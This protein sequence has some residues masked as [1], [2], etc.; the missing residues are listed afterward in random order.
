MLELED[1]II[2]P[3]FTNHRHFGL[4]SNTQLTVA[5]I[6]K[7]DDEMVAPTPG[8]WIRTSDFLLPKE[9]L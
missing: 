4:N 1:A 5:A 3:R 2:P 6:L 9:T 7:M 8:D